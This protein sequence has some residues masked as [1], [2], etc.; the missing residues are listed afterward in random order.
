MPLDEYFSNK[1]SKW[2][3]VKSITLLHT[4]R[5]DLIILQVCCAFE[6]FIRKCGRSVVYIESYHE[7]WKQFFFF[8]MEWDGLRAC[9]YVFA[10]VSWKNWTQ[11]VRL[12]ARFNFFAS[13][14]VIVYRLIHIR[15]DFILLC[16]VR[17]SLSS[18]NTHTWQLIAMCQK[19]NANKTL[20]LRTWQLYSIENWIIKNTNKKETLSIY[21]VQI[22]MWRRILWRFQ[23]LFCEIYKSDFP[24]CRQNVCAVIIFDRNCGELAYWIAR[25]HS[26][27][28]QLWMPQRRP[29]WAKSFQYWIQYDPKL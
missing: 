3:K 13:H 1:N 24:I 21:S 10:C 27:C 18:V 16:Y 6:N 15:F 14:I 28:E 7:K 20:I 25:W 11:S 2:K 22:Q 23:F 4:N 8:R 29:R 12:C 9:V 17:V 19:R 5:E 26:A